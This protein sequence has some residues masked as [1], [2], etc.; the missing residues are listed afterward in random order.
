MKACNEIIL[1]HFV[2]KKKLRADKRY[3]QSPRTLPTLLDLAGLLNRRKG[4]KG[5]KGLQKDEARDTV[6]CELLFLLG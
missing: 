6:F 4:K 5:E 2:K 1:L 3:S